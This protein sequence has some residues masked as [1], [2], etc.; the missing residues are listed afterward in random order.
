MDSLMR[1][2]LALGERLGGVV[3]RPRPYLAVVFPLAIPLVLAAVSVVDPSKTEAARSTAAMIPTPALKYDELGAT[4]SGPA[5]LPEHSILLA[6]E[7]DDTLDG[8]LKAGG[9][10]RLES[11]FLNREIGRSIDL[12]RLRPGSLLRFHYD[13][14]G[15]VDSVEM[16]VTGWGELDAV[17]TPNGFVVT[18]H[19]VQIR[20]VRTVVAAR[21]DSSLWD[22]VRGAGEGPQLVQKL[23]DVFQWD[24][25][26]FALRKGDSFS[27]VVQKRY[28]G[29]DDIG[30]G[31]ILAARFTHS[32]QT[33]EAFLNEADGH[34]GYYA[35]NGTPLRKAFLRAPL[36]F[37][38]V[39]ST[40]SNSRFHPILHYFRPHHGVDYGAPTGTPVMVTADGVVLEATRNRGEGNYV[41]VRHTSKIETSYLHLSRFG[42]GIHPGAH[43]AQGQ[44]IGYVGMTGLATAPHLDYRISDN[45]T[46]LDPL[47]F[48]SITPDPLRAA[49]L[50]QFRASV[51]QLASQLTSAV[52]QV[53]E[54]KSRRRAL[55]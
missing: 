14:A 25:D 28:A 11:A 29:A 2:L 13:S 40:F 16:K 19:P 4:P 33:S 31:P 7:E 37:T 20:E 35:A 39:T 34:G 5:T 12:R 8:I 46:W 51:G 24:I 1:K 38:R 30:Y 3:R 43:V 22:S 45:G 50:Q 27:V 36:A 54:T 53:A 17:R 52:T 41:K 23:V 48:K 15:K 6:V 18:P 44:V 32:G 9:L 49:A 10:D 42:S 26:F 47:K 55:F 21:I